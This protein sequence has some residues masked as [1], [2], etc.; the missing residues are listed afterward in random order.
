MTKKRALALITAAALLFA[1]LFSVV[2]LAENADHDCTREHC[3]ICTQMEVC[4]QT[5]QRLAMVG[6]A[7]SAMGAALRRAC[8]DVRVRSFSLFTPTLVTLKVKL[9][10]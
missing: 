3:S 4:T 6:V 7:L 9:S 2:F 1:V 10:N 5:L 8:S